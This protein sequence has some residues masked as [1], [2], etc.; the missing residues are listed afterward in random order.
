MAWTAAYPLTTA[1]VSSPPTLH[2]T[3]RGEPRCRAEA[4]LAREACV[5]LKFGFPAAPA[6]PML[7]PLS[8]KPL[9]GFI[10]NFLQVSRADVP[11]G[12]YGNGLSEFLG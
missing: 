8:G 11:A 4:G 5:G 7:E 2:T 1:G 6:G 12:R 10:I 9:C 3:A